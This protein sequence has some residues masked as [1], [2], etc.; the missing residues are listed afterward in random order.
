MNTNEVSE[1]LNV[2]AVSPFSPPLAALRISAV[3]RTC[4][5]VV[6]GICQVLVWMSGLLIQAS[7]GGP[8]TMGALLRNGT[9]EV[10]QSQQLATVG[11]VDCLGNTPTV[12]ATRVLPASNRQIGDKPRSQRG[13]FSDREGLRS[14]RPNRSADRPGSSDRHRRPRHALCRVVDASTLR[15][16]HRRPRS[17]FRPATARS[18]R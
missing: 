3:C 9:V 1:V 16:L 4:Q 14:A 13:R 10:P 15:H 11:P 12:S 8:A 7:V 18:A 6:A 2:E 5:R 17:T